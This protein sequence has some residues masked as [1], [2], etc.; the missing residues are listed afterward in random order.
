[1]RKCIV[2]ETDKDSGYSLHDDYVIRGNPRKMGAT[3]HSY[4]NYG[5]PDY[6]CMYVVGILLLFLYLPYLF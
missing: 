2:V 5:E 1:M 6:G 4:W 3:V